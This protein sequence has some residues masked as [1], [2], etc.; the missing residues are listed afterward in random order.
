MPLA[1]ECYVGSNHAELLTDADPTAEVVLGQIAAEYAKQIRKNYVPS[2]RDGLIV[3]LIE[4]P[5]HPTGRMMGVGTYLLQ[6][7]IFRRLK[8]RTPAAMKRVRATDLVAGEPRRAG[9]RMSLFTI[10]G[11]YVNINARDDLNTANYLVRDRLRVEAHEL[12]YVVD[13]EDEGAASCATRK[14]PA[15]TRWWRWPAYRAAHRRRQARAPGHRRRSTGTIARWSSSASTAP[16]GTSCCSPTAKTPSRRAT[17]A[18]FSCTCAP[19]T[20]WWAP[21]PRAR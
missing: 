4:K 6:P 17:S 3:D 11:R 9:V 16:T 15:S 1:D 2:L 7:A 19:Q 14:R 13:G 21:A 8:L 10:G 5:S 18:S 20:W 12:V